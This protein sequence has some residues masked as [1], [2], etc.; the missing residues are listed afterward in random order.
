LTAAPPAVGSVR[1][2]LMA[3]L[4]AFQTWDSNLGVPKLG[5]LKL[6]HLG[7]SGISACQ[8]T[9]RRCFQAWRPALALAQMQQGRKASAVKRRNENA[10]PDNFHGIFV[11]SK[12]LFD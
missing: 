1:Y 9:A 11:P 6:G 2:W 12:H 4:L 7:I 8:G 5:H 3:P 10:T